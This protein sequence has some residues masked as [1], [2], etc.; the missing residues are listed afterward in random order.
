MEDDHIGC[1]AAIAMAAH[2]LQTCNQSHGECRHHL[3]KQYSPTRVLDLQASGVRPS[4]KIIQNIALDVPYV[5]L[6]HRWVNENLPS[7]TSTNLE[8]RLQALE[9]QT[10]TKTMQDAISIAWD[11]GLRYLWVDALCIIQD[12]MEDWLQ[13][14]SRMSDVFRGAIVTI[15]VADADNH[16]EGIFRPRRAR[17]VRPF[18]IPYFQATPYRDRIHLDREGEFY[19]FPQTD[20]VSA[21]PRPKGTLDTR[22]WSEY[23][24]ERRTIRELTGQFC[25]SSYFPPAYS[26]SAMENS[27]GIV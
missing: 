5:A 14:A 12:S 16:S 26:I 15:A 18:W 9:R 7:T 19:V 20:V 13:E 1:P 11:L 10:R 25:K 3:A 8:A 4:V 6:S 21:G 2:W 23:T 17:C 24:F 22:G 27:F